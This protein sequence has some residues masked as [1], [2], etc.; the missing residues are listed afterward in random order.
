MP[1]RSA[2]SPRAREG[3]SNENDELAILLVHVKKI[4]K[5]VELE[6]KMIPRFVPLGERISAIYTPDVVS[7]SEN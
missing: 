7:M 1:V 6:N 5:R 4:L 3:G 2:P